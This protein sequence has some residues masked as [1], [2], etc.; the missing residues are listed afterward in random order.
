[1]TETGN[2]VNEWVVLMPWKW[3][4]EDRRLMTPDYLPIPTLVPHLTGL[5]NADLIELNYHV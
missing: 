3:A 1:M 2:I 4:V 5:Q